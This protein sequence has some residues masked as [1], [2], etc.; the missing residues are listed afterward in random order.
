M[1]DCDIE[2][3][4]G[5]FFDAGRI[6]HRFLQLMYLLFWLCVPAVGQYTG[7][8]VV[9]RGTVVDLSGKPIP[10]VVVCPEGSAMGTVTD[11]EGKFICTLPDSIKS[12]VL[13]ISCTGL[14]SRTV[15]ITGSDLWIVLE[16]EIV[17]I[18]E[19][20]VTGM[21]VKT[22]ES[23][24]GSVTTISSEELRRVGNRDLLTM[25]QR[26]DP[27][28]RIKNDIHSG[29]DPNQLPDITLRGGSGMDVNVS[30]LQSESRSVTNLPLFLLDGFEIG[31]EQLMDLDQYVVEQITLLKDAS[32]TALY[33][34]RGAN[35]IVVITTLK[36]ESGRLRISYKG[37]L[38]LEVP[39]LTSYNMMNAREKLRFEKLAG[40]YETARAD[41]EQ[42]LKELYYYRLAEVERGVDTYWLK[43]P[44]HIGVGSLNKLRI[45][46]GREEFRYALDV[47][48]KDIN[49]AMK[50]SGRSIFSGD[51]FLGYRY[52]TIDFR[53]TL[54]Y[55]NVKAKKSPYGTFHDF[56]KVNSYWKPYDDAGN[57]LMMLEDN[58][59][60][61]SVL[62]TNSVINPLWNALLPGINST[63][64]T[65]I[66]DNFQLVWR[67]FPRLLTFNG[68][69]SV[70][71]RNSRSDRY[72]S[73]R[74]TKYVNY[75]GA[76]YSRKGEYILG[77]GEASDFSAYLR[78]DLNYTPREKHT[79]Y[80]GL[81]V[82]IAQDKSEFISVAA[83][84][85]SNIYMKY[86]GMATLYEKGGRPTASESFSRRMGATFN[87]NY[88]YDHRYY[89]DLTGS[90]DGSS[91][92][93]GNNRV[94]PFVAIGTGWNVDRELFMK[95]L[96]FFSGMRMRVS[97]GTAGTQNFGTYQALTTFK[98]Y[99]NK[100]YNGWY[101]VYMMGLGN[102]DLGWQTTHQW[103]FGTD[104]EMWKGRVK[105]S[106]DYYIKT[107]DDLLSDITLPAA[108]GFYSYRAN[109]GKLQHRGVDLRVNAYL[110]RQP[111]TG[112]SWLAGATLN[113][114]KSKIKSISSSLQYLNN[115]L[116]QGDGITPV[117]LYKEG[118]SLN[119]IFA[120]KSRGIDPANGQE[121]FIKAGGELTYD[122]D[123]GDL[124]P[125]G[126]A[127]P[128]VEGNINTTLSYR[129]ISLTALFSYRGG[130]QVYNQTLADK[131]EN[132][133]PYQNADKRALYDRWSPENT[134]ALYKR[135][136]DKSKTQA[137]SRFVMD[138]RTLQCTNLSLH[139]ECY[140]G[141]WKKKLPF[142]HLRFSGY[143]EDVFYWS[144]VKR[145]RGL[146]YPFSRKFS[147][148]VTVGF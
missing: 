92:Y 97:Y 139:Y 7:Q 109:V 41:E 17:G 143:M 117:F 110:I 133:I 37:Q 131:V 12:G 50:G 15:E 104:L 35:G 128:K 71:K 107:T 20:V 3:S 69:F 141:Q 29:S 66:R 103:N 85:I 46:G 124:Q 58:R 95:H 148:A 142:S 87:V 54:I 38:N 81:N 145:E 122:W 89:V 14:K 136:T 106:V 32:A 123:A 9:V 60:Y 10:A 101:G 78:F 34:S 80:A 137:S 112:W 1:G 115:M 98:D 57:L 94:A 21:F 19:V 79:L 28:F 144:T 146:N 105:L 18:E 23:Y 121:I 91:K 30:D 13:Q 36:P 82:E 100:H 43:Y 99:G 44:V 27:A 62:L 25:I 125:C 24:T 83:E 132:I 64:Y 63:E 49:G 75:T 135:I 138:E 47:Q 68:G 48:Y 93:G 26:V 55:S 67:I 74:H 90:L 61:S 118:Q 51:I 33:G 72:I 130:G 73:S 6:S 84:G 39:D 108:S 70:M 147:L 56:S 77:I 116:R 40:L 119:T 113:Y 16:E 134:N 31:L 4:V 11:K 8:K 59:Y 22:K 102:R 5:G 86:I 88:S 126:V 52:R 2:E 53:N 127:E 129:N 120:V 114:N 76:D 65:E 96:P 111:D 45:E 42:L 140:P